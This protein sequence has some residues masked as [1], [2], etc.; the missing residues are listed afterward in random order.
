MKKF[1]LH[2]FMLVIAVMVLLGSCTDEKTE[3]PID[4]QEVIP[5]ATFTKEPSPIPTIEETIEKGLPTLSITL[6]SQNTN[7]GITQDT[8]GDVDTIAVQVDGVE[9]RQSGN[10]T[11][12]DSADGNNIPGF[13][14]SI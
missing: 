8:G 1:S 11:A 6:G 10:S 7:N 13:L 4:T 14:H 5:R 9:A 2:F 12:L 3:T